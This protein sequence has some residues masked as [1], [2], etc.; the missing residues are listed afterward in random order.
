MS[1]YMPCPACGVTVLRRRTSER[2][3]E[4]SCSACG[5]GGSGVLGVEPVEEYLEQWRE[6]RFSA[7]PMEYE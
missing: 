3:Y 2:E 5:V 1:N 7:V 4:W 6:H